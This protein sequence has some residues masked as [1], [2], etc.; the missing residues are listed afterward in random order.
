[1]NWY[2]V[3]GVVLFI[4]IVGSLI[5]LVWWNLAARIAPYEDEPAGRGKK[6]HRAAS[7][8][9]VDNSVI[10]PWMIGSAVL[11][12]TSQASE[13]TPGG[14]SSEPAGDRRHRTDE[15]DQTTSNDPALNDPIERE[16]SSWSDAPSW[17][18]ADGGSNAGGGGFDSGA[19]S[20]FGG[21]SDSGGSDF[22]G[23][24]D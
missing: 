9:Q 20:D 13:T 14:S 17:N 18:D 4:L 1:M 23:S 6:Q 24:G 22:G 12:S 21:S 15:H 11:G 19:G 2:L 3:A 8:N 16:T 5:A 10:V 7:N